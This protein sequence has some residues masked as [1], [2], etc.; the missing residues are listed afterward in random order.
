MPRKIKPATEET[1]TTLIA[2]RHHTRETIKRLESA[3]ATQSAK[4][5]RSLL[6]SINGALRHVEHRIR[7]TKQEGQS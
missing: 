5:A 7:R 2:A 6:N 4:R 3:G 1:R